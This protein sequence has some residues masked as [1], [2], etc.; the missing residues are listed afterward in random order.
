MDRAAIAMS[1]FFSHACI[2]ELNDSLYIISITI[3]FWLIIYWFPG[4]FQDAYILGYA[5]TM[6]TKESRLYMYLY[7]LKNDMTAHPIIP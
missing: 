3:S 2:V 6:I 4:L 5:K 1:D 7:G